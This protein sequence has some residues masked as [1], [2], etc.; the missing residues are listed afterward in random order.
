ME[1][2]SESEISEITVNSNNHETNE[3]AARSVMCDEL[4][5]N[6]S[7]LN[8]EISEISEITVNS[9]NHETN[10]AA[11]RSV[12]CDEPIDNISILNYFQPKNDN[13]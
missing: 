8:S 9:N 2:S 7:I 5:D 1:P 3:A 4:I 12:M 11:T 6:I 10:E 13:Q